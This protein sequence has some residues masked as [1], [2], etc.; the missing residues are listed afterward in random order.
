MATATAEKTTDALFLALADGERPLGDV[1]RADP[2][3]EPALAL[4]WVRGDVEFGR[5]C[6]CVTGRPGLPESKPTLVI[7]DG[8][9]WTGPK[10]P[11]HAP[12]AKIKADAGRLPNVTEYK[13]YVRQVMV[14]KDDQG[15]ER[16]RTATPEELREVEDGREFRWTTQPINRDEAARLMAPCVRLTDKG[17][18]ALQS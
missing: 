9:D 5:A 17:M 1:L 18:A 15:V 8:T 16:W 2:K 6:H 7:E 10:T 12:F 3:A 4:A 11:K 13:K 14:G